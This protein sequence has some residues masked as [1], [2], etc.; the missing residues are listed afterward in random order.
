VR[1][2]SGCAAMAIGLL[3]ITGCGGSTK[4]VTETVT[5][6]ASAPATASTE[7]TATTPAPASS[8]S[9]ESLATQGAR[10]VGTCE[11][12]ASSTAQYAGV[13]HHLVLSGLRM[14]YVSMTTAPSVSSSG[15]GGTAKAHGVFVI[16]Q[17]SLT[18]REHKPQGWSSSQS[19]L[20]ANGNTYQEAFD[21]ENGK[22]QHSLLWIAGSA[23]EI[24]PEETRTGDLVYDIPVSAA[25]AL[26]HEGG[27]VAIK[28]FGEEND[29]EEA[30]G[31][32]LLLPKR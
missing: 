32:L 3:A 18:N 31:G 8:S 7:S 2:L 12:P 29:S 28:D 16:V 4:T 30:Y 9:C 24:Q 15:I 1:T 14:R 10:G 25:H 21:A 17:V 26:E 23:N 5:T 19:S 13:G 27:A 6:E 11:G 22:D 20:L